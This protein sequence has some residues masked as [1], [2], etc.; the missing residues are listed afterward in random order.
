MRLRRRDNGELD[1]LEEWIRLDAPA[2]I[3]P[4]ARPRPG[5]ERVGK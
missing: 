2:E 3:G 5:K 1:L 4:R